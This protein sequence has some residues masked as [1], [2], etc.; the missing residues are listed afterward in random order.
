MNKAANGTG[1]NALP[2]SMAGSQGI[3]KEPS[4]VSVVSSWIKLDTLLAWLV[5]QS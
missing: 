5:S 3:P 4:F 2:A 1:Y